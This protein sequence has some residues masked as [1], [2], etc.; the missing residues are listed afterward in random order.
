[1]VEEIDSV[2][3]VLSI[4]DACSPIR[5]ICFNNAQYDLKNVFCV[6]FGLE[7]DS[8]VMSLMYDFLDVFDIL[9]GVRNAVFRVDIRC[10]LVLHSIS[11]DLSQIGFADSYSKK[12]EKRIKKKIFMITREKL[13]N[14]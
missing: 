8:G 10:F 11:L 9:N 14:V 13:K 6:V 12:I 7:N 2:G 1:M 3:N 5:T 4:S